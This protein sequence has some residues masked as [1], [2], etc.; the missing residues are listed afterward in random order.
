MSAQVG[1]DYNSAS[2]PI[3]LYLSLKAFCAQ[4]HSHYLKRTDLSSSL[5]LFLFCI[6][7]LRGSKTSLCCQW[8]PEALQCNLYLRPC[9]NQLVVVQ[10]GV[11][12]TECHNHLH[13]QINRGNSSEINDS[14]SD[15]ICYVYI[16]N[17]Y[18]IKSLGFVENLSSCF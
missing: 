17:W 1:L 18:S 16:P 15:N 4:I 2:L 11:L 8:T 5:P 14:N 10:H 9:S 6:I 7:S 12:N 3:R 13:V